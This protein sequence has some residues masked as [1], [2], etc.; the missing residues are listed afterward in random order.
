MRLVGLA[1]CLIL[2]ACDGGG[3]TTPTSECSATLTWVAPSHTLDGSPIT[4][5]ELSKFTIF[6]S[7]QP[8]TEDI[9]REM[10]IDI[11]NTFLVTWEVKN[12]P[13]GQHYFYMTATD[14]DDNISAYSNILSKQC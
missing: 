14:L 9:Y 11:N 2:A 7:E 10:E 13:V 8:D 1:L 4:V 3:G 12:I 5:G 6:L